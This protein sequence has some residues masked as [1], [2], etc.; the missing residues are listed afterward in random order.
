MKIVSRNQLAAAL[1]VMSAAGLMLVF[2]SVD[3]WRK[4]EWPMILLIW[5]AVLLADTT[6]RWR[7]RPLPGQE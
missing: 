7:C 4:G 2:H 3:L 5:A 1:L 6:A